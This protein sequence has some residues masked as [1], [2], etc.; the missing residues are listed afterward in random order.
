[1][2][3]KQIDLKTTVKNPFHMDIIHI[4]WKNHKDLALHLKKRY[5]IQFYS[6]YYTQLQYMLLHITAV[7]VTTHTAFHVTIY[8]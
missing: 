8:L 1:M 3:I 7:H 4:I 5:Y 2:R 6:C